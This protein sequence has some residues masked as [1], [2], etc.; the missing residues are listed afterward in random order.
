[1]ALITN[2]K[3]KE[4]SLD[5]IKNN[6]D[7]NAK[8]YFRD[9][10][11][12]CFWENKD[13]NYIYETYEDAF[14]IDNDVLT[15]DYNG[16]QQGWRQQYVRNS[17]NLQTYNNFNPE[18]LRNK[19]GI[20]T[21]IFKNLCTDIDLIFDHKLS[22]QVL[23]DNFKILISNTKRTNNIINIRYHKVVGIPEIGSG[24]EIDNGYLN[25]YFGKKL[26]IHPSDKKIWAELKDLSKKYNYDLSGLFPYGMYVDDIGKYID[27][28]NSIDMKEFLDNVPDTNYLK[29]ILP[30]GIP[31]D[32]S[33][34]IYSSLLIR[35]PKGIT[36]SE[37]KNLIKNYK[38]RSGTYYNAYYVPE[39]KEFLYIGVKGYNG[40]K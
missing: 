20:S 17:I 30:P 36:E 37:I 19:L 18:E 1:M 28:Y 33:K 11:I 34:A 21:I 8:E 26:Y 27:I 23:P 24:C 13:K 12:N 32:L 16:V 10:I 14:L 31:L 4:K 7:A 40:V 38:K 39:N 35:L 29:K 5:A 2:I 9:I 6:L 15:I 3:N 25:R 22:N